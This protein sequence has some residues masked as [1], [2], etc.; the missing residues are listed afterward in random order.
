MDSLEKEVETLLF[1]FIVCDIIQRTLKVK[2][3]R[4]DAAYS[5]TLFETKHRY[6]L[7]FMLNPVS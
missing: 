3:V 1:L 5:H 2:F 4:L 6:Y 7:G